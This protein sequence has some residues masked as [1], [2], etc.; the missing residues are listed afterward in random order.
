MKLR[1]GDKVL[2]RRGSNRYVGEVLRIFA[3]DS[4]CIVSY[5]G[6]DWTVLFKS[7]IRVEVPVLT[8]KERA[9]FALLSV[10]TRPMIAAELKALGLGMISGKT[11]RDLA[12]RGLVRAFTTL[13]EHG[14]FEWEITE[15]GRRV[16]AL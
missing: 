6:W 13:G 3:R 7:I 11:L 5:G 2:F 4:V 12:D 15:E 10:A 8:V 14:P 16:A 1:K 9:A